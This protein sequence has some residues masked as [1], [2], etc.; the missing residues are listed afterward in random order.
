MERLLL[1]ELLAV[2]G[3]KVERD[4]SGVNIFDLFLYV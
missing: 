4:N 3:D 2:N 1:D